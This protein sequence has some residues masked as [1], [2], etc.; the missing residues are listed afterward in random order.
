MSTVALALIALP[1]FG[2]ESQLPERALSRIT[3]KILM[4]SRLGMSSSGMNQPRGFCIV[5]FPAA[6]SGNGGC[7]S[8]HIQK[9]GLRTRR[10]AALMPL[11]EAC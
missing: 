8:W 4:R 9:L 6:N 1:S 10:A 11:D 5:G 7:G 3:P 2:L